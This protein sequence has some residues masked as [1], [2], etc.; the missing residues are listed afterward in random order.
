MTC[1]IVSINA[2]IFSATVNELSDW[3]HYFEVNPEER[4]IYVFCT[5]NVELDRFFKERHLN[6]KDVLILEL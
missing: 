5:S 6:R 2:E 3:I 4:I 1:K